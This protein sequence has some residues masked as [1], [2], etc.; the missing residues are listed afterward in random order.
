M[1]SRRTFFKTLA[2]SVAAMSCG[3]ILI[4]QAADAYKWKRQTSLGHTLWVINPEYIDAPYEVAI[5]TC[6][7]DGL[8]PEGAGETQVYSRAMGP[9]LGSLPVSHP[10]RM[11]TP[12]G[13]WIPPFIKKFVT[14]PHFR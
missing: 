10:Y 11:A 5:F 2:A 8:F 13:P 9:V 12:T 3:Q 7:W 14:E 1:N 4:P 6:P